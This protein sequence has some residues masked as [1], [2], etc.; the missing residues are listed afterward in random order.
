MCHF[1]AQN[2]HFWSFSLNLFIMFLRIIIVSK[3]KKVNK[4]GNLDFQ[5]KIM[6]SSKIETFGSKNVKIWKIH[7]ICNNNFFWNVYVMAGIQK[8]VKV[9]F[10]FSGQLWLFPSNPFLV[11]DISYFFFNFFAFPDSSS[12]RHRGTFSLR[13]CVISNKEIKYE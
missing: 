12:V 4:R 11:V 3:L 9:I 13:T 7:K 8:E 6:F 2:P 10:H 1:W 5:G